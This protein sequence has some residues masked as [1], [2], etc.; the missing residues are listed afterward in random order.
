MKYYPLIYFALTAATAVSAKNGKQEESSATSTA[1]ASTPLASS[2]SGC[3]PLANACASAASEGT[4][5]DAGQ[6]AIK[7]VRA[8][9]ACIA[10][11]SSCRGKIAKSNAAKAATAA[12]N[13][14]GSAAAYD[15]AVS[16]NNTADAKILAGQAAMSGGGA[17]SFADAAVNAVSGKG[18]YAAACRAALSG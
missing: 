8:N 10:V 7:C 16:A 9:L 11:K 17:V 2:N 12:Y 4:S 3:Q 15:A 5:F 14:A 13:T 1:R 6:V 18:K